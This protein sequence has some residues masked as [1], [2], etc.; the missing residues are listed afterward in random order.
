MAFS[1]SRYCRGRNNVAGDDRRVCRASTLVDPEGFPGLQEARGEGHRVQGLE[2]R[3][4]RW[5]CS[6]GHS[7]RRRPRKNRTHTNESGAFADLAEALKI[8][9]RRRFE[10]ARRR[11]GLPKP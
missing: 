8:K 7:N 9:V 4:K 3:P 6:A 10:G 2:N 11:I 1:A 5:T